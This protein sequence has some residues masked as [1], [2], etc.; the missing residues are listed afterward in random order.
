MKWNEKTFSANACYV[1]ILH[2]IHPAVSYIL[3]SALDASNGKIAHAL[4]FES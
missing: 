2:L 4:E 3:F 1:F